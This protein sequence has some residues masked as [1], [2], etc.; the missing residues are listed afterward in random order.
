MVVGSVMMNSS[1]EQ[2]C[3]RVG[4]SNPNTYIYQ[5]AYAGNA[6][7]AST[8]PSSG[9]STDTKWALTQYNMNTNTYPTAFKVTFSC[10][11]STN[12]T[13]FMS[14]SFLWVNDANLANFN[15][16]NGTFNENMGSSIQILSNSG[17]AFKAGSVISL[18]GLI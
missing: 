8:V 1:S 17:G 9:R 11:A 5:N 14:E 16:T 7:N 3:M 4:N 10:L 15:V 6:S 18:Y 13:Q 2:L 12:R